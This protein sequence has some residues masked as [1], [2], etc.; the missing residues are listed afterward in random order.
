MREAGKPDICSI[1]GVHEIV[2]QIMIDFA[3]HLY[4]MLKFQPETGEYICTTCLR[5]NI[6]VAVRIGQ[7]LG[8]SGAFSRFLRGLVLAAFFGINL[9]AEEIEHAGG[10]KK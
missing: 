10:T 4:P 2:E 7:L 3:Y 9:Y 5:S 1:C 8:R 6:D